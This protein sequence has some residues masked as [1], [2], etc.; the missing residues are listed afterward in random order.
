MKDSYSFWIVLHKN[1][2]RVERLGIGQKI[3]QTFLDLI[4]LTFCLSYMSE[5]KI[6]FLGKAISKLDILKFF[7]QFAW[8]NKLIHT[9]KYTEISMKFQEIGRQL[10]AWRKGLESKLKENSSPAR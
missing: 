1:F 3:E 10:G 5:Q 2:P 4:E 8:E 9:D 6:L 7:T